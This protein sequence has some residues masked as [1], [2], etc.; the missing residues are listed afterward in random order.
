MSNTPRAWRA[1]V[2]RALCVVAASSGALTGACATNASQSS[3]VTRSPEIVPLS[4]PLH[5]STVRFLLVN[6]V[7]VADGQRDG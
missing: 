1:I 5:V 4:A 6:D 7:Y 2:Q 3:A